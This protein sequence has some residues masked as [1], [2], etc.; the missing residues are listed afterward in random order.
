MSLSFQIGNKLD[1]GR[2]RLGTVNIRTSN[3]KE[4]PNKYDIDNYC[5]VTYV[6]PD[7]EL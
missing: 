2:L 5:T 7:V 4:F 6:L 1:T 3:K